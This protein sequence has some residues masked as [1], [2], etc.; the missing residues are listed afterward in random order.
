MGRLPWST[1][2]AVPAAVLAVLF[3]V[4]PLDA[5]VVK[6]RVVLR[7]TEDGLGDVLVR[8]HFPEGRQAASAL[9]DS[10]GAFTMTAPRLGPFT[11][12]AE[13]IG[14]APVT[15]PEV[16]VGLA[17]AVEVVLWMSEAAVPLEPLVIE[18]RSSVDLGILAG[19]YERMDR[20]RKLGFGHILTRDQID[21]RQAVDVADLLRDIPR[22][23]ILG[24]GFGRP[25]S[26]VFSGAGGECIPRVYLDGVH[27]N[28]GGA[29]GAAAMVD[30]TARPHELEGVEVYR[31]IGEMPGEFYDD[32]HC[33]VILLWTRRSAEGRSG[34]PWIR[35]LAAF[36]VAGVL[37]LLV[38]R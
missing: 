4:S 16:E 37:G 2:A 21:E 29:A 18:A 1:F 36:L 9:T 15:T 38:M 32:R 34:S 10:A 13:R 23:R 8:L 31:G 22:V 19:Y 3:L 28:R 17:E 5:Q 11:L 30:E 26:V 12:S 6:G 20:Q 27:Q 25:P 14:L 24:Q 35:I 33:G 7:G